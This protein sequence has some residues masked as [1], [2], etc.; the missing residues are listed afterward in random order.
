M[1]GH[2]L[3]SHPDRA[4]GYYVG[5]P[6]ATVVE[7]V[8]EVFS[9]AAVEIAGAHDSSASCEANDHT[10]F[11]VVKRI[12]HRTEKQRRFFVEIYRRVLH[13]I[14]CFTSIHSW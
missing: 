14:V 1:F 9:V 13:I 2:G 5:I 8:A 6:P 10:F 7:G 11:Q 12:A 4:F 3:S